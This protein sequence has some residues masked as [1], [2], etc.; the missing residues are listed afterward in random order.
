MLNLFIFFLLILTFKLT[1]VP[2]HMSFIHSQVLIGIFDCWVYYISIYSL[3]TDT[4]K[5]IFFTILCLY[6]D[7]VFKFGIDGFN[8]KN[9][10]TCF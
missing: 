1:Q 4:R 10:L 2:N 9:Y 7:L 8:H 6:C 3:D 5:K